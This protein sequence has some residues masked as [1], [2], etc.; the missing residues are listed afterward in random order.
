MPQH[1]T[2]AIPDAPF[3]LREPG[4]SEQIR[5]MEARWRATGLFYTSGAIAVL[6][7]G[8]A[9]LDFSTGE[10]GAGWVAL[11]KS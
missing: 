8:F 3:R 11:A 2:H 1:A 6:L 10:S 9:L 4:A 5:S 7:P